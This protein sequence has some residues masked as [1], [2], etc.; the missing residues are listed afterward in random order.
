M[1]D[2]FECFHSRLFKRELKNMSTI[3]LTK[4]K[5]DQS[6]PKIMECEQK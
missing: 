4:N 3:K 6:K 2:G 5:I 1:R